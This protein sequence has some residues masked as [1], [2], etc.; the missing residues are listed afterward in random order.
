MKGFKKEIPL[1]CD[2]D[3]Y[4]LFQC[5]H[6]NEYF[7]LNNNELIKEDIIDLFCPICGLSSKS[8]KFLSDEVK[9]HAQE[10]AVNYAK[11]ILNES[12]KKMERG[13]KGMFKVTN[14]LKIEPEKQLYDH[15]HEL[16]IVRFKCC[17]KTAKVLLVDKETGYCPYCGV[18]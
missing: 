18:D 7:K 10:I 13:S 14:T 9:K 17:D 2:S 16:D 15:N 6:C 5:P 11:T 8:S 1:P 3:G 12:F 4:T